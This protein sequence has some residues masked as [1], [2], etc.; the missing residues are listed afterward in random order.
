MIYINVRMLELGVLYDK[1]GDFNTVFYTTSAVFAIASLLL[2]VGLS[3]VPV[4]R[5]KENLTLTTSQDS[6]NIRRVL[7]HAGNVAF[8]NEQYITTV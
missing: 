1:T 6:L 5:I 8:Y 3:I 2:G 4:S 7:A